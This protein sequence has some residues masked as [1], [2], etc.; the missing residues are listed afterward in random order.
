[1]ASS[2]KRLVRCHG[3]KFPT[4][5][6]LFDR[7]SRR[8]ITGS[9]DYLIKIWCTKTGYLINTF[10]GHQDVVTDIALNIEN[11]LLAS[12]SAD[13]TVRIWNLKSG[14]PRAVLVA[15]PHGR[16]KSITA[17][18]F[19]PSAR[20]EIRFLATTC[21]DG[22][23]RLYR[24]DRQALTFDSSPITIDGRPQPRGGVSSFAFNHTGSRFAIATTS[25]YVS[26]YSTIADAPDAPNDNWGPPLLISRVAA[27]EE[28][29]TT[30]VFSNNGEMF[31]TGSTDGT[32]KVW[33][34]KSTLLRWHSITIDIK[35]PTPD[36]TDAPES[37]L[38]NQENLPHLI[39]PVAAAVAAST[40]SRQIPSASANHAQLATPQQS[41]LQLDPTGSN[42]LSENDVIM[43]ANEVESSAIAEVTAV[44]PSDAASAIAPSSQ[45][46]SQAMNG[47]DDV[48][49]VAD[50]NEPQSNTAAP[51]RVETNQVAWM[52]D[53]SRIMI[54]NNIGTVAVFDPYTGREC[55]RRRA[56]SLVEVYVLIPHPTDP[57][58]AVSGGYDG[59]ALIWD[60]ATGDVL[61]EFRVGEPLFDGSFSEDGAMFALTGESGAA[62]LFG[63]GPSWAYA[64]AGKMDEQ[65]FDSDYTATIMD[66]NRFVADQQTQ[67]PAYLVPHGALM[68]FDGHVYGNQKGPRFGMDIEMGVDPVRFAREDAAR[69]AALEVEID[70]AYLD[71]RAAQDP[72]AETRLS[73]TRR[74]RARNP[75]AEPSDE[76][77]EI[78]MPPLII[79]LDDDSDD[80]EYNAAQDED[81]DEDEPVVA[82]DEEDESP[83]PL[84]ITRSAEDQAIS[85]L[86]DDRDRRSALEILR[87]RHR[88]TASHN[89]RSAP[90]RSPRRSINVNIDTDDDV[91]IDSMDVDSAQSPAGSY[92]GRIQVNG[93]GRRSL[94][95]RRQR[96]PDASARM[97]TEVVTS[98]DDF[99]PQSSTGEHRTRPI[100]RR[101]RR[102]AGASQS[103]SDARNGND[104]HRQT[105]RRRIASDDE[106][107]DESVT[108]GLAQVDLGANDHIHVDVDIDGVSASD[109]DMAELLTDSRHPARRSGR[110]N[111]SGSAFRGRVIEF[112]SESESD[113]GS[114][115]NASARDHTV[116]TRRAHGSNG[117]MQVPRSNGISSSDEQ[118]SPPADRAQRRQGKGISS[119]AA[120]NTATAEPIASTSAVAGG[121]N[122]LYM[123]TDWILA[124][125]PST[126]PYRPQIGDIIVYFKEG[127]SDFWNSPSRCMKLSEKL[128]PYKAVSN[129]PVAVYGKVVGLQY[130]V[131]PPTFCT[132][133]VQMLQHQTIDELDLEEPNKHEL[134]RRFI[135]IQYHDCDGVPD[136]IVL[137]SRYRASLRQSLQ[138]GDTV[139]V[140][141]DE[142]QA[143]KGTISGFREI[144]STSRQTS[145][146]RLIA[147]NP[148]KSIVV[149]WS[150]E[151]GN[152]PDARTEQ[153]SPWELVHDEDAT[154]VEIPDDSKRRL[155]KIVDELRDASEFVWFVHNVDYVTE[156][157]NYLL[158]IAYPMCLDTIYER[159][160]NNFYRQIS[161]VSF[162]MALIQENAD[163]FNDPGTLVPIAAQQ[164]LSTYQEKMAS[165]HNTEALDYSSPST[166]R[167][168][169]RA[170]LSHRNAVVSIKVEPS[171]RS[172]KRKSRLSGRQNRRSSRRRLQF[173]DSDNSDYRSST[174]SVDAMSD[175]QYSVDG[176]EDDFADAG[177][178]EEE[179][180]DDL[181]A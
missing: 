104:V 56:H 93:S 39:A 44:Q 110:A 35:E 103:L 5:C 148:W 147:R 60:I 151:E 92:S 66:E 144:K 98:D 181:Y 115:D 132:V 49:L 73:R 42:M 117:H 45:N 79:P 13:G 21:D 70:H 23:C 40:N 152:D 89:L 52:C 28:S 59:R 137:Y 50:T 135:Q 10:K 142:D 47:Q 46:A 7:T 145:V 159:L 34:C 85:A 75:R 88:S 177:N 22:L 20:P 153:V 54:S 133:K 78:E 138:A 68:D 25:G 178:S 62:T 65:M 71:R 161:A 114:A 118:P 175:K 169:R 80:E 121:V 112:T 15:N 165:K 91:D 76:I 90:W 43:A 126:V 57:R 63:L 14:E 61:R 41:A 1:M 77:P 37:A 149:E 108:S 122:G 167:R 157:P 129:L 17:V 82:E 101:G 163:I 72:I 83:A 100:P 136:F 150:G 69:L 173:D 84:H 8:M 95:S 180:D 33:S 125:K 26:I 127:H 94:R 67:I 16:T 53:S 174:N 3:H 74:R 32:V 87:S 38:R 164:L 171:G 156:Y 64:D 97:E 141:F 130:S 2:F 106:S 48:E 155:L 11:T 58:L 55:W 111:G 107:E 102:H 146:T 176:S 113:D 170:S 105:R 30:L 166:S 179:E 154:V 119:T 168:T 162:D 12:A 158:N 29:I 24:W 4:F 31:L 120:T 139:S 9:D 19:S 172:R 18:N 116:S 86:D 109:T 81:E 131:G 6:A 143:H 123:P 160:E 51:K 36:F 99:Q 124:T 140:L 96:R 134:T 27:H 128:L